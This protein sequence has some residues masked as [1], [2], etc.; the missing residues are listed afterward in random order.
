[1]HRVPSN[2]S[3]DKPSKQVILLTLLRKPIKIYVLDFYILCY[4][5]S[6]SK[7]IETTQ[8]FLRMDNSN[9]GCPLVGIRVTKYN[10][11]SSRTEQTVLSYLNFSSH[12]ASSKKTRSLLNLFMKTEDGIITS[13]EETWFLIKSKLSKFHVYSSI[14]VKYPHSKHFMN[15]INYH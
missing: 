8:F 7:N 10:E 1:M 4:E 15:L 6:P 5:I 12:F 3:A 14:C 11:N 13:D 2:H 9:I